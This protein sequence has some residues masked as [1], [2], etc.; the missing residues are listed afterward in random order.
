MESPIDFILD[1]NLLVTLSSILVTIYI[2]ALGVPVLL[3]QTFLPEK[4]REL[5]NRHSFFRKQTKD[6]RK[7]GVFV[8]VFVCLIG[9]P[10]LKYVFYTY[11]NIKFSI[12]VFVVV[13]F[14]AIAYFIGVCLMIYHFFVI[15]VLQTNPD[16]AIKIGRWILRLSRPTTIA[17]P[18]TIYQSILK[19]AIDDWKS[20]I[21]EDPT[22]VLNKNHSVELISLLHVCEDSIKMKELL[23][24][25]HEI[26]KKL[27][28]KSD[29]KGD[30]V[31]EMI[32]IVLI[33][34]LTVNFNSYSGGCLKQVIS[35]C[36]MIVENCH[37]FERSRIEISDFDINEATN[38][39]MILARNIVLRTEGTESV[40]YFR[41]YSSIIQTLKKI[42][43]TSFLC[44][45]LHK[46][47]FLQNRLNHVTD[48]INEF[49]KIMFKPDDTQAN[50]LIGYTSW[51]FNSKSPSILGIVNKE[52]KGSF[53]AKYFSKA[54]FSRATIFFKS[55]SEYKTSDMILEMETSFLTKASP[56]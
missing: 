46:S 18:Q 40:E 12:A 36:E 26:I 3:Q 23:L 47:M 7:I 31:H 1:S 9:N 22:F 20:Q 43:N 6:L 25:I 28:T 52:I 16:Y 56:N 33:D 30:S 37:N 5:A 17:I 2:F 8:L 39:L 19:C 13:H 14:I 27:I 50:Y 49:K 21:D 42:P 15:H 4:F 34:E 24:A 41:M 44:Y 35:I 54:Q 53:G 10:A 11:I 38:L 55:R 48:E 29:Y 32:R 45:Q 51:L